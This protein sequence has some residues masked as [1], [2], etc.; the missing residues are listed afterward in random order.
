MSAAKVQ[1]IRPVKR[2]RTA[3]AQAPGHAKV[4]ENCYD[5]L[6]VQIATLECVLGVLEQWD[7]SGRPTG[8]D[9]RIGSAELVLRQSIEALHYLN[10]DVENLQG[11]IDKLR[12]AS[13]GKH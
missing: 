8:K 6:V 5:R 12:E 3:A 2:R 13:H 9:C 1:P 7:L 4:A 10:G 11:L